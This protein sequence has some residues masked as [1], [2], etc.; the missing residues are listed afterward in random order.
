[1]IA[2]DF[3]LLKWGR[4][5][6]RLEANLRVSH[7]NAAV[8]ASMTYFAVMIRRIQAAGAPCNRA[9]KIAN[10]T[11]RD[12]IA[13]GKTELM[14][15]PAVRAFPACRNWMYVLPRTTGFTKVGRVTAHNKVM[16]CAVNLDFLKRCIYG[17]PHAAQR[18]SKSPCQTA[19]RCGR[20]RKKPQRPRAPP[21]FR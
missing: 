12:R 18:V 9:D 14:I 13:V 8:R 5:E 7:D 10:C 4:S 16:S 11:G 15:L 3:F 20:R 1:M 2:I 19:Y 6:C 21:H 17:M